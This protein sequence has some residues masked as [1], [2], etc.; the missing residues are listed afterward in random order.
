MRVS[1]TVGAD[2]E[3]LGEEQGHPV[4]FIKGKG[5]EQ[6][7]TPVPLNAALQAGIAAVRVGG[8]IQGPLLQTQS[9]GRLTRQQAGK[10]IKRLGQQIGLPS[11][12]PHAL[13]HTF[14]TLALNEGASLRDVQDAARHADPRTTRRYDRD[15][16]NLA[17]HPTHR[18]LGALAP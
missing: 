13:R 11:L 7:R 8:R 14:V 5:E 12:H 10:I 6:K 18:L 9:G 2:V 15:R 4:L 1:E 3:D 16:N 17:R